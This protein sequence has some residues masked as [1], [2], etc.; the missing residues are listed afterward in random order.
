MRQYRLQLRP[1]DVLADAN[2]QQALPRIEEVNAALAQLAEWGKRDLADAC[3]AALWDVQLAP[4]MRC[5]G[6]AIAEEA[7]AASLLQG[8]DYC[9]P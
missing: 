2:W 3:V 4:A 5:H 1:D 9:K 8:L 6:L 7:V